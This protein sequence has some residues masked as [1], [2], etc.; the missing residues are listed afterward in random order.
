MASAEVAGAESYNPRVEIT[1]QDG[2]VYSLLKSQVGNRLEAVAGALEED[3][4]RL[5]TAFAVLSVWMIRALCG[6]ILTQK[7]TLVLED[8]ADIARMYSSEVEYSDENMDALLQE[9]ADN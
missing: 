5:R 4:I 2:E 8:V 6:V 1:A 3:E 7:G 9:I